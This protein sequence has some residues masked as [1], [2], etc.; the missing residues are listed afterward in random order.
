MNM[1][2]KQKIH[3]QLLVEN[4]SRKESLIIESK[5]VSSHLSSIKKCEDFDC[6]FESLM[7]KVGMFKE[8]NFSTKLI[9][10][11]VFDILKS[12]F[13][14][15]DDSFYEEVKSRLADNV[16][17]NLKVDEQHKDCVKEAI[18]KTPNED[19]AKLMSDQN[20]VA[21]K[22]ARAY[23]ECFSD[24]VLATGVDQELGTAGIELRA[25]ITN[26]IN[27]EGFIQN[28]SGKIS[29][30]ISDTLQQIQKKDEEIA[31][32]IKTAVIGR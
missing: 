10:E 12:L 6:I 3:E 11:A 7:S 15:L 8:R 19:V 1:G 22:I 29:S 23:V 28:L 24:Q 16:I 5:I 30:Q 14:E 32:E 17:K 20:Y 27:D 4:E 18:I 13:G 2:L 26:L 9:N 25:A 31:D 21:E